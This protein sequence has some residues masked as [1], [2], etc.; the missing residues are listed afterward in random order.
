MLTILSAFS[1]SGIR[2]LAPVPESVL[3]LILLILYSDIQT[4]EMGQLFI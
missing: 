2:T 1:I 3:T 4:S